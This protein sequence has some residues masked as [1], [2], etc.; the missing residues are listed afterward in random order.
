[1]TQ[2]YENDKTNKI[3]CLVINSLNDFFLFPILY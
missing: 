1:M 3:R 2:I